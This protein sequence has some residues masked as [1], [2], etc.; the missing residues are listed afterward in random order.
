MMN[1]V[2]SV[3][4][5]FST[6]VTKATPLMRKTELGNEPWEELDRKYSVRLRRLRDGREPISFQRS[7]QSRIA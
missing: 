7:N 2:R 3:L 5:A 6:V 1:S 4:L